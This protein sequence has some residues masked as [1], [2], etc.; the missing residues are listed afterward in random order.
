VNVAAHT[1]E[2]LF[3]RLA[4]EWN[5]LLKRSDANLIFLTWEWQSTWWRAY[6]AG[7]LW[8]LTVHDEHNRLVAIAPWFIQTKPDGERVVRTIGCVDVTDY[9]DIIVD[10]DHVD[11]VQRSLAQYAWDN[12]DQFDRMNLCNVSEH[13]RTF[14]TFPQHLS[15]AGFDA[16]PVLQEVCPVIHL[17]DSFEAY[18]ESLDKKQRH[19]IRR[20]LRRAENEAELNWYTVDSTHDFEQQVEVFFRLMASSQPSKAEFLADARNER[21]FRSILR[22]AYECGWL[23]MTFLEV[24]GQP[25]A[26]YCDFVYQDSVLVYNS[27]LDPNYVPHLSTGIVLLAYN[28]RR[29]IEDGL[30]LYDFLR[31]NES[32]KYRMGAQDTRVY[33]LL[34]RK[35]ESA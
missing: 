7:A 18:L 33:M 28:I 11:A 10:H 24:D 14:A 20:K 13:S 29:A 1:Q 25:A 6:E 34:A 22:V 21:F 8:V 9:M 19:E 27:G 32:Y 2:S 23:R 17:P 5:N 12:R 15:S 3:D 16:E 31:G 26:C 30:K 35:P 4:P